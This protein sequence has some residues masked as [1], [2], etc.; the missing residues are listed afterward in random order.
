M[1]EDRRRA[2]GG[3]EESRQNA[4]RRGLP[5]AVGTEQSVD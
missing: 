2:R 4:N 1:P 5:G 3:L